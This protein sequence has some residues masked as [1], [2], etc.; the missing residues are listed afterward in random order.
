M[1]ITPRQ[2]AHRA[3]FYLQLAQ[4]TSA[5]IG[6]VP[7]LEQIKRNPPSSAFRGPLQQGLDELAAGRTFSE[8]LQSAGWL[9]EFDTALIEAG[10]R[11]GRLDATFRLLADY[12]NERARVIKMVIAQLAYPVGLI[13][14]AGF[15]FLVV[16]PFA[17]SQFNAS[18]P[19]LCVKAALILSPLYGA[20]A[21]MIY[22]LQGRHGER[23]RSRVESFLRP[24]PI[25]GTARHSLALARLSAALESLISAGVNIIDAW[26]LAAT[27]S[28]SPALRRAVAAWKPQ[29]TAGKT[30]AETV[31]ACRLF[32]ETFANLY[33]SGE[34]SGKLDETLRRLH[35]YYQ[36]EGTARL[37]A[38]AQWTPRLVYLLVV[39]VIAYYIISF[40]QHLYGSGSLLDQAIHGFGN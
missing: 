23:W 29:I 40:F 13:H 9:P 33:A 11:S 12:Y 10:E 22:A 25:L 14:F 8:S 20:A 7:A 2:F 38:F 34:V 5:G 26:E 28:G 37:H 36:E 30:P 15:I 35:V 18:L 19:W 16:V 3:E 6:V 31:R 1:I 17:A 39:L 21:L 27:A 4:L 24:V 32:P